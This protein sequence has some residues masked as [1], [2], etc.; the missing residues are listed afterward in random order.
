MPAARH[1]VFACA[2]LLLLPPAGTAGAGQWSRKFQPMGLG[3]PSGY[4]GQGLAL[5]TWSGELVVAG[6]F[7][8]AGGLPATNVAL[9]SGSTW[10]VLD[11]GPEGD[12]RA[13]HDGGTALWLGGVFTQVDGRPQRGVACWD[14]TMGMWRDLGDAGGYAYGF[15][16][17]NGHLYAG[18]NFYTGD[19]YGLYAPLAW[20]DIDGWHYDLQYTGWDGPYTYDLQ[21]WGGSLY[22]GGGFSL[23][24]TQNLLRWD[25]ETLQG[26]VTDGTV[27]CLEPST[28]GLFAGGIFDDCGGT[29]SH[30]LVHVGSEGFSAVDTPGDDYRVIALDFDPGRPLAVAS[31]DDEVRTY[32]G[33]WS[34]PLGGALYDAPFAVKWFGGDLYAGGIFPGG[35][36][37]YDYGVD[38]WVPLG[39][40]FHPGNYVSA[41]AVYDG[42][43]YAG[44]MLTV[45]TATPTGS[46]G[47]LS[48]WNGERWASVDESTDNRIYAL[49][50]FR[51]DLIASGT[52]TQAGDV[53]C[54]RIARWD[55][56]SW[57]SMGDAS[58]RVSA[59]G[60]HGTDLVAGGGF[61]TIGGVA[62]SR[63]ATYD[64]TVWHAV[65]GAV[66]GAV[67]AVASFR[68]DLVIGGTISQIDGVPM[69]HI[70]RW[71]GAAWHPLG[72][73]L[74]GDV[75]ALAVWNNSLYAAGLFLNA[76]GAPAAGV[77]RWDGAAWH[78]LGDGLGGLDTVLYGVKCLLPSRDLLF[79]GGAFATAGGQPASCL[80]AWNGLDWVDVGQ[81]VFDAP[82]GT[83]P[84]VE[85]LAVKDGD[86]YVGGHFQRAGTVASSNFAVWLDGTIV[87]VLLASF[88]AAPAT[89]G[90]AR[91]GRVVDLAWRTATPQPAAAFRLTARAGGA[92]WTVPFAA[93]GEAGFAARDASPLLATAAEATY[94]LS[95]ADGAGGWSVLAER[96]VAFPPE[97]VALGLR[98]HPN[99][100]N[101]RTDLS[102][103]LARPDRVRLAV[104]DLSGRLVA[105]LLDA[106]L[107]AGPQLVPWDGRDAHGRAVASGAYVA[108]LATPSR[109]TST[110]LVLL[111]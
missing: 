20:H 67:N 90:P 85:S 34:A 70:A 21:V 40:G 26:Y 110:K 53:A 31:Q 6:W 23:G 103:A 69:A 48:R 51:G 56:D 13:V 28:W 17:F 8:S 46:Y 1:V 32:D 96:S 64:G 94:A 109:S 100:F 35:V 74:D 16:E 62:A 44:G 107:P 104:Y 88:T 29:S 78:A 22:I 19:S 111:R 108:R 73:G 87:P 39:G 25:T 84:R 92:A 58:A 102:F 55:G 4:I 47:Y 57:H 50:T 49:Q 106:D 38:D 101:P 18:G 12:V 27:T 59:L 81:G 52:F 37:R 45:S 93:S 63:V 77:A 99:P 76:G 54:A 61:S 65:G 75:Y 60:L 14:G 71:D 7:N 95:L 30:G 105:T 82:T 15:A 79:V 11:G 97:P 89:G 66:T 2:L 24:G 72:A 42:E 36:A 86:L 83:T 91:G 41:L 43:V 80:A 3:A 9:W 98:A 33:G 68:G 10:R 5:G